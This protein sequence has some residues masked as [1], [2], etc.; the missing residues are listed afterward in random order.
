M[1]AEVAKEPMHDPGHEPWCGDCLREWGVQGGRGQR[2]KI[3][4]TEIA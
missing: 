4:T 2:E 3:G 1:G